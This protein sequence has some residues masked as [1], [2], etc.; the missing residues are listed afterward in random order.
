MPRNDAEFDLRD[1]AVPPVLGFSLVELLIV[2][3]IMGIFAGIVLTRFDPS[4]QDQLRGAAQ[5]VAADVAFARDLAVTNGS[6]YTVTFDTVKHQYAIEHSGT[7]T[8]LDTLPQ[9][10]FRNSSD[11]PD[12]QITDLLNLPFG[13]GIVELVAVHD[14]TP[15]PVAINDLEFGPLGETSRSFETQIWLAAGQD[16]TRRYLRVLVH[17][18]TGLTTLGQLQTAAPPVPDLPP[19]NLATPLGK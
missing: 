4:I 16:D 9:T 15:S 6:T 17:P 1:G 10:P 11:P 13:G 18:V 12:Q 7:N 3:S 2:I 5:I 8:V 14:L 19:P